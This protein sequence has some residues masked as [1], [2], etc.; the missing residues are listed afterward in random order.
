MTTRQL[1]EIK[2]DHF[3][4]G[5]AVEVTFITPDGGRPTLELFD[6]HGHH[7]LSLSARW[8]EC[9]LVLNSNKHG[10][11]SEER[12]DGFDFRSGVSCTVRVEAARDHLVIIA[13]GKIVHRYNHRVEIKHLRRVVFK[14]AHD[15]DAKAKK[16]KLNTLSI[17]Y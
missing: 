2:V 13:N 5:M 8:G 10:W 15:Q 14:S 1:G 12:P 9:A 3:N 11:G 16:A 4:V 7:I 6:A 17:C